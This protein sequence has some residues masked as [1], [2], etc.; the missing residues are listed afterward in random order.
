[1]T[2]QGTGW[3]LEFYS[4]AHGKSPVVEVIAGLPARDRAKIRNALRLLRDF[5]VL[6]RMPHAR[7]LT[8]HKPL[9]ELR[10]GGVRLLYFA[11]VGR[12]F[13]I[14][15]IFRKKRQ[16]TPARHIATAE[17][18]MAEILERDQ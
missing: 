2:K 17:R 18:R 14:L 11:H 1:M 5:G 12:R 16:K 4:D 13:I 15:H 6:L 10:P 7:P 8:G 3:V 9:W